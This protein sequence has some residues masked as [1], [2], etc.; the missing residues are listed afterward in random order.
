MFKIITI[1]DERLRELSKPVKN[2]DK[3]SLNFANELVET[4]TGTTNPPGVGLSAIQV[5]KHLQIFATYLPKD[6]NLPMEKWTPNKMEAEVFI[7]PNIE[8]KSEEV[9]LGGS[10]NKPFLEG[11]LSMPK[12]YGPVWRH[13]WIELSY[14]SLDK[15]SKPINVIKKF[16]DFPARVVQHEYDHLKGILF[17]DHSLEGDLPVYEEQGGEMVEINFKA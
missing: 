7:N 6:P 9:T 11:C 16:Q 15:K 13:E 4:L 14:I 1:P 5:A 10:K 3:K 2:I 12:I 8:S 17:T